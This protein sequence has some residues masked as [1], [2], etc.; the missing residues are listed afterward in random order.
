MA[1]RRVADSCMFCEDEPCI[2][3]KKPKKSTLK[4][5]NKPTTSVPTEST[6]PTKSP[7]PT[8]SRKP[9][10]TIATPDF[11]QIKQIR[12]EEDQAFRNALTALADADLLHRDELVRHR[13]MID[14]PST[15]IDLMI[16]RQDYQA[17]RLN[18]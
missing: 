16:W 9:T 6:I 5:K 4:P 11:T 12:S 7:V 10:T 3:I 8:K 18:K 17:S 13:G 2:C 1:A 14:L 15:R